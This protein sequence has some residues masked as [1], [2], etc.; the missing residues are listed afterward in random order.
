MEE[1]WQKFKDNKISIE[2]KNLVVAQFWY[3]LGFEIQHWQNIIRWFLG[4]DLHMIKKDV[5]SH[6]NT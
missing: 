2:K 5:F 3:I 4:R 1:L 6:V